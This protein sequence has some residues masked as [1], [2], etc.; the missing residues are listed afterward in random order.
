VVLNVTAP[1]GTESTPATSNVLT[2]WSATVSATQLGEWLFAWVVTGTESNVGLGSFQV[3]Q[4]WYATLTEAKGYL[5]SNLGTNLD[6]ELSDSLATASRDIDKACGR[7]FWQSTTATARLFYPDLDDMC[8]SWVD[9][10]WST[11]GLIV[12]VGDGSITTIASSGYELHPLNGIVDGEEGWPYYKLRLINTAWPANPTQ[13]PLR[14]TAKWG[15]ADVPAPVKTSCVIL[16]VEAMKLAR[17]APFGVA[18]F[19]VDGVVRIRSNARVADMLRPYMR[20][21]VLMA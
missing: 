3:G 13:A 15:W 19:G 2:T 11:D 20:H 9:D 12:E 10:F 6:E 14:V 8:R 7:K 17:E 1:D 5:P 21:P 18:G 4:P 16:A